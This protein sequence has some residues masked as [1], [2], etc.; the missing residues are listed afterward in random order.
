MKSLPHHH[1]HSEVTEKFGLGVAYYL[2]TKVCGGYP[3]FFSTSKSA[4]HKTGLAGSE[5]LGGGAVVYLK[6]AT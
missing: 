1:L 2:Y 3:G 4:S 6:S 5:D